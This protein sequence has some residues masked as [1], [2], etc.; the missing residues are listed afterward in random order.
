MGKHKTWV[1]T[2]PFV[3]ATGG[4]AEG[5]AVARERKGPAV[6]LT[7]FDQ[8]TAAL[9]RALSQRTDTGD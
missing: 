7:P 5:L 8:I 4:E 6:W 2:R 1:P 9:S 3:L